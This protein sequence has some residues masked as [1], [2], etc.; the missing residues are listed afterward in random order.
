MD[1]LTR[2]LLMML[3]LFSASCFAQPGQSFPTKPIRMIVPWTAGSQT[4]ILARTVG[5]KLAESL[6]QSV[7]IDNRPGAGGTVGAAIAA[8]ATPDGH[9][10]MMQAAAHAISPSLYSKLPY[11]AVGDFACISRIGSVPNVLVVA[12]SLGIRSVKELIALAKQKPGQINF[13]SAGIGGGTHINGEQFKMAAGIN[14]VH[15]PHR[16]TPEALIETL[17]GRIHY[18]FAP[19]G[20]ALPFVKDGRLLPLGVSTL[21]RSPALPDVPTIAEAAFP[22]FE[23]DLWYGLMAPGK[24][25]RKIINQISTEVRRILELPDI[26]KRFAEQGV[27]PKSSTPEEF[28]KFLRVEVERLGKIVKASGARAN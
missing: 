9:T 10:L 7:V 23:F 26:K 14:V 15:V 4:D 22:G 21:E 5:P 24:V 28:D 3:A 20:S 17:T 11:D 6:G 2:V 27:V 1:H 18:F 13:T 25:P 8:I 19:L 16:G 12:P